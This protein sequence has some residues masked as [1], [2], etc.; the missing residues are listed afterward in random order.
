VVADNDDFDLTHYYVFKDGVSA[1]ALATD[2]NSEPSVG[3]LRYIFRLDNL[4]EAYK[5]GEV[6]DI[7]DGEAIEASDVYL[8]DGETRSKVCIGTLLTGCE[9]SI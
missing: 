6:S 7:V 9:F 3:E 2:A 8:V 5:E 4:P 1:I